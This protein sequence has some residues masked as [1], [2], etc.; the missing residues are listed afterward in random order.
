V[1]RSLFLP[2]LRSLGV[3]IKASPMGASGNPGGFPA[4][5]DGCAQRE[6]SR[7]RELPTQRNLVY[8]GLGATL[9]CVD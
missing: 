6:V 2:A 5:G 1:G 9:D 3:E 8:R 4:G 7:G